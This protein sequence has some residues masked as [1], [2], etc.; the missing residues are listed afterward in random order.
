MAYLRLSHNNEKIELPEPGKSGETVKLGVGRDPKCSISL[1]F[2][3]ITRNHMTILSGKNGY[4]VVD[5]DST[6]GTV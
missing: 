2:N 6:N 5:N 3:E 4:S 1:N